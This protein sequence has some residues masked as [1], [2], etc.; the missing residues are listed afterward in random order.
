MMAVTDAVLERWYT[1]QFRQGS[2]EAVATTR[3]MLL[4]TP[5]EGYIAC[6]AAV[7]D[8][9]QREE[10]RGITTPTLVVAGTEDPVT[11][12]ADAKL[13]AA[14]I[15]GARLLELHAAHLSNIE[16]AA[17]FTTEVM[18]FLSK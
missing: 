12:V 4:N 5:T 10:I 14:N 3:E 6:C 9:D 1:P 18:S 11:T 7:R 16:A 15:P 17:Q 8:M 2:A 13:T